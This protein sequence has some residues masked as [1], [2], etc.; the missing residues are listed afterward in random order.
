MLDGLATN[1][2]FFFAIATILSIAFS[3]GSIG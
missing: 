1:L 2:N 3:F